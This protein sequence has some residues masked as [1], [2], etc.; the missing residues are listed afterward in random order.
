MGSSNSGKTLSSL[1]LAQGLTN[2][3][4]ERVCVLDTERGRSKLFAS[5]FGNRFSTLELDE[6]YSPERYIEALAEIQ[7]ER[8][9]AGD[10]LYDV[11]IID[12][13][14]HEWNGPGGIMRESD[15]IKATA[16]GKIDLQRD[17]WGQ[18]TPRHDMFVLKCII[19]PKLHI[20]FTTRAKGEYEETEVN[21]KKKRIKV[22][23]QDIQ[24]EG[25]EYEFTFGFRLE[26]DHYA[27]VE[28]DT[29]LLPGGGS[30]FDG[31][32]AFVITPDTGR[33]IGRAHV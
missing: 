21:G 11:A 19:Q 31:N 23:L 18:L 12:S 25:L 8:D 26:G 1:Y 13:G 24:R 6:P 4:M 14:S 17:V 29:S 22:G 28:K 16:K 33:E 20:I 5:A 9:D 7:N 30:L 32:P 15:R 2:D 27:H 10:A 3:H